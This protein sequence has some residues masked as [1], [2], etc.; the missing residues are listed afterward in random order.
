MPEVNERLTKT[1][2]LHTLA[3]TVHNPEINAVWYKGDADDELIRQT[4]L[5]SRDDSS[6]AINVKLLLFDRLRNTRFESTERLIIS[7]AIEGKSLDR[8]DC[9][10][11]M[12][13]ETKGYLDEDGVYKNCGYNPFKVSNLDIAYLVPIL[14]QP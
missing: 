1:V 13:A 9:E 12:S 3:A 11:R 2:A 14:T 10:V 6:V 7:K 8:W 5:I 4:L